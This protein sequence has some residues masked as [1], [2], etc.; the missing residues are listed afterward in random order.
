MAIW[1]WRCSLYLETCLR[2]ATRQ[3]Q[4]EAQI[5]EGPWQEYFRERYLADLQASA[6]PVF[7][8]AVGGGGFQFTG[9]AARHEIFP[10]LR[11]WIQSHYV[12]AAEQRGVRVY[13]R[14]DRFAAAPPRLSP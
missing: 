11:D 12:K 10:A 13:V 7:V 8:D 4:S 6:P 1:G 2:P 14:R 5:R 9:E 3:P